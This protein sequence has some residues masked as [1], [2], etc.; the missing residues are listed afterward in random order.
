MASLATGSQMQR[1]IVESF[2]NKTNTDAVRLAASANLDTYIS[3]L[4][5]ASEIWNENARRQACRLLEGAKILCTS[6]S[7]VLGGKLQ[8]NLAVAEHL[9]QTH[10]NP[11]LTSIEHA[12]TVLDPQTRQSRQV[13]LP[14]L[15][16]GDKTVLRPND[17]FDAETPI[18]DQ[19]TR[20]V[21]GMCTVF[22]RMNE[23]GDML[24]VATNIRLEDGHRAIGTCITA[25]QADG[26]PNPV[27]ASVLAGKTYLG[28]AFVVNAW[29]VTAYKPLTGADGRVLGMLFVGVKEQESNELAEA[30]VKTQLGQEGYTFVMDSEG[31]LVVH[32][33]AQLVGKNVLTDLNLADLKAP[34]DN[35]RAD[36]SQCLSYTFEGRQK[37][38][39]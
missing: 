37:F 6:H 22:Q 15:Q 8:N 30:L 7:R 27:V 23:D 16:I 17:T 19:A 25:R 24:R 13:S 11:G 39:A 36:Q 26:Q 20:L 3:A 2:V 10:G 12:W 9:L 18:V 5:G 35:R 4:E 14:L 21:G 34:L 1:A 28:R 33:K 32:P 29:C 31:T 38:V